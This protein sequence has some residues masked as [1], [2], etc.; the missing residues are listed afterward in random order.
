MKR[1]ASAVLR[2]LLAAGLLIPL[3]PPAGAAADVPRCTDASMESPEMFMCLPD[4]RAPQTRSG[5]ATTYNNPSL[6]AA[7][8]AQWH[9]YGFDQRHDPVFPGSDGI[10]A[11]FWAAPLT[12]LDM[13]RA[14]GAQDSFGNPEGWAS[15]TGQQLGEVMGVSVANG[16]V[17]SQLGRREVNALDALT[18]RRIWRFELVNIASMGQTIVQEVG[19]RPM[20]FVPVGDAAFNVYNAVDFANGEAHDRGASFG[21]LYAL[22]GLTG[23]Q[24]WRFDVKGA[25]RPAP[26]YRDG[27]IY[28]ATSGGELFVL[29][30]ATGSQ[31]GVTTNPGEGF[32]GLASPNWVE[33]ADGRLL[34]TYGILRPRRIIAMDVTNP[35]APTLAW[36]MSPPNAAAN[37]PGDTP[38]AVDPDLGLIITTVFSSIGGENHLLAHAIEANSGAIRWTVDLGAGDSPPGYKASVP[39]IKNGNVYVGNTING[40]FWSLVAADGSVRWTTD[41]VA[42]TTDPAPQRPRAAAAFYVT[43][44]GEERLI[45]ASGRHVRTLD[46][47]TGEILNDFRTVG[48][49]GLFGVAQPAIVGKQVYLSAISG[50]VFSAPVDFLMTQPGVDRLPDDLPV[51]K[52]LA[53]ADRPGGASAPTGRDAA[54]TP[55]T[56]L[57][58]AGGQDNNANVKGKVATRGW[59]TA[60]DDALPLEAPPYDVDIYGPEIAT[61]MTHFEFG[62]GSGLAVA[63]GMVY[64]SSNRYR[65]YGINAS[66]GDIVW[67]LR[68][69]NRNFGQPVV[70]PRTVVVGGGDP[71]FNLGGTGA[72]ASQSPGTAVGAHL[73]H[74]TGLDPRTGNE[75]W[76]VWTGP[77]T[78]DQT[79]LYH[80]GK[81]YWINGQGKLYAVDADRGTP[82][83]PLMTA[84]GSPTITL[85]GFNVLSSPN[86]YVEGN[87]G[88]GSP[89][90]RGKAASMRPLMIVGLGMPARMVALELETGAQV[91]SQDLAGT[92]VALTGFAATSVAVD[93]AHGVV[94]GSVLTNVD[95]TSQ[96]ATLLAFGLDA[97]TGAVLW[98]AEV[99]SGEYPEGWVASTPVLSRVHSLAYFSSPITDEIVALNVLTG[100][101][102]WRAPV[103][104]PEGKRTWGPGVLIGKKQRALVH[105]VG[106]DLYMFDAATGAVVDWKHVGGS[107]TYNNPVAV[108]NTLFVGN[109]WGWVSAVKLGDYAKDDDDREDRE[110]REGNKSGKSDKSEKS[111]KSGKDR[112]DD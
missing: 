18:G 56:F 91:W 87:N 8:P 7:F 104:F 10:R 21:S 94:V 30:P 90:A 76:T 20:V 1:G 61:Q 99:G 68:T 77:G 44:S 89:K 28:L 16:I 53:R 40:T 69:L 3:S 22:D 60:L 73:Q 64:A 48:V 81:L 74:V 14:I 82:V 33:T 107:M 63:N 86:L 37:S 29:D 96:T 23:R 106:P 43:D 98:T 70:T 46:A 58:Y 101:Q 25:A 45:H 109:S 19:G 80:R 85:D 35:S 27:K 49:F 66:N 15:R 6:R 79:P 83:Q 4:S 42:A 39:M 102:G 34:I 71:Y 57:F 26:I 65:I 5:R 9:Q 36:Q 110:D 24:V 105:P 93:Q 17:Y 13:L 11:R 38:V 54:R 41:F 108:G 2:S 100:A 95:A 52:A 84:D 62:V 103:V 75:K 47:N 55:K 78:S 32:P 51:P 112:D 111:G 12:G 92:N 97:S 31:I 67:S 59:N 72:F 50:W 88:K